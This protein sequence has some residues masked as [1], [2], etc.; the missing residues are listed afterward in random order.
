MA[1]PRRPP[2]AASGRRNLTSCVVAAIFLF[3]IIVVILII[4]FTIF[5]VKDPKITVTAVQLPSFSISNSSVT[6]TFSQ[7]VSLDNPNKAVFTHYD[8]TLRVLYAGVEV[9]FMFIPSGKVAAGR[10]QYMEATFSVQSFPLQPLSPEES[11]SE[12]MMASPPEPTVTDGGFGLRGRGG[13][14]VG[15][16]MQI[17][18]RLE[19]PGRIRVL[20]MVSHHVEAS[21]NCRVTIAVS[22]GSVSSFHC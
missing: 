9:G 2:P 5:K 1:K 16:V 7:H 8:S 12:K 14:R 3:F 13:N 20:T 21:V 22:E 6:F 11:G 18:S 19:I 4:F 15:P 10:S 17:Q